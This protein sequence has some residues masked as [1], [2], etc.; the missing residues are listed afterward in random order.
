MLM[1]YYRIEIR[2]YNYENTIVGLLNYL[3]CCYIFSF[4]VGL[5]IMRHLIFIC[6][7]IFKLKKG[8]FGRSLS[9]SLEWMRNSKCVYDRSLFWPWVR[10]DRRTKRQE[11]NHQLQPPVNDLRRTGPQQIHGQSV[12][13]NHQLYF[14]KSLCFCNF[15]LA[16]VIKFWLQ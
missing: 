6:L 16:V 8:T 7:F 5:L 10:K 11:T 12:R 4:K 13:Q 1:I 15:F 3:L 14:N 2:Q 9:K